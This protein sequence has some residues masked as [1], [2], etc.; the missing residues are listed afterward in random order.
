MPNPI[1]TILAVA[2][3]AVDGRSAMAR[4]AMS[5]RRMLLLHGSGTTAGAFVNSPTASGARDFLSGIP[6]AIST[7]GQSTSHP[8]LRVGSRLALMNAVLS[9]CQAKN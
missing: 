5:S 9:L 3:V 4:S 2:V 1:I 8:F 7:N 6:Y